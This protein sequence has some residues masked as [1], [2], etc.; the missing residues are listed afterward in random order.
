MMFKGISRVIL[1]LGVVVITLSSYS[2]A[3][4]ANTETSTD[5]SFTAG[6]WE[7]DLGLVVINEVYYH[8]NE[9]WIE[10]YN[11][12][13]KT[14][15]IKGWSICNESNECGQL[16]PSKKT[17]IEAGGFVLLSHDA[18][19]LKSWNVE[20]GTPMIYYAGG[21]IDFND[22]GDSVL[23]KNSDNKVVDMVSYGSS[24]LAFPPATTLLV[25]GKLQT[26]ERQPAGWD[27][28]L[29]SDFVIR[30]IPTP[31]I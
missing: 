11:P 23:L 8:D 18:N 2:S 27:T 31:G 15:D 6:T 26:L 28:N 30:D 7:V 13:K 12:S 24:S 21:R 20:P 16:N 9:E 22:F 1:L 5:N 3:Y 25:T 14:V 29:S 19:D 4:F 10:L 17:E